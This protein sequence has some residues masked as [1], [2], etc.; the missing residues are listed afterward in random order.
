MDKIKANELIRKYKEGTLSAEESAL[1]ESWY[2]EY[3]KSQH[4]DIRMDALEDHLDEVWQNL[5]GNVAVTKKLII[6]PLWKWMAA[7]VLLIIG[8]FGILEYNKQNQAVTRQ[9]I[10]PQGDALPGDNRA[11]LTLASGE[12]I[13]LENVS[14]GKVAREGG[15]EVIKTRQGEIVYQPEGKSGANVLKGEVTYNTISTPK[16]GQYQI[17]LPDGT[18]VWLNAASSIR[19][20][21]VFDNQERTVEIKGEVYFEVAKKTNKKNRVPFKVIAGSQLIEVLGT[22]FN[23]NSY[24]DEE[25]IKTT[26]FEGSIKLQVEGNLDKDIL[27]TPGQQAKYNPVQKKAASATLPFLITQVDTRSVLAWKNGYFR[28]DNIGLPELMRQLSRWYDMEVVYEGTIKD[29]EFVGQIERGTNLSKVLKILELGGVHFKI[30]DK[31]II[32]TE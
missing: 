4:T 14:S 8:A 10:V 27:L 5:P 9:T 7:A 19:F 13:W 1:L 28:F 15:S 31:K 21:T 17:R 26:L 29:Y 30:E 3:A 12:E 32:V 22:R 25:N 18:R 24:T 23:V 2:L 6:R 11:I 20:P 16:A